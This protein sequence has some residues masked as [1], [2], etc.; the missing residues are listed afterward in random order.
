[1]PLIGL[2]AV[3][4]LAY[5]RFSEEEATTD[6]STSGSS[7]SGSST[8]GSSTSGSS[9]SGS[10]SDSTNEDSDVNYVDEWID[11]PIYNSNSDFKRFMNGEVDELHNPFSLH[12]LMGWYSWIN[13]SKVELKDS[14]GNTTSGGIDLQIAQGYKVKLKI[15]TNNRNYFKNGVYV[16][17]D[18]GRSSAKNYVKNDLNGTAGDELIEVWFYPN[19]RL[20]VDIDGEHSG[21]Y[22]FGMKMKGGTEWIRS[23]GGTVDDEVFVQM[24]DIKIRN[25]NYDPDK[26]ATE[27]NAPLGGFKALGGLFK[28]IRGA[29]I[30]KVIGFGRATT[31]AV[32]ASRVAGAI[33]EG[34]TA[35][36]VI[37]K[38]ANANKISR[39]EGVSEVREGGKVIK[40]KSGY[41]AVD[42]AGNV[43]AD[44]RTLLRLEN[45]D[46]V[47]KIVRSSSSVG[48]GANT[49]TDS[50]NLFNRIFTGRN[51]LS[52]TLVLVGGS[53]A[54]G[55]YRI[56]GEILPEGVGDT[57]KN[58]T[59]P[60]P[61]QCEG[62]EDYETCLAECN[63][64]KQ[65]TQAKIGLVVV[66]TILGLGLILKRPS[67]SKGAEGYYVLRT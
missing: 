57:L 54:I 30:W 60:C 34:T 2:L 55:A 19:D 59:T 13:D 23:K 64:A 65:E 56:F 47:V 51:V 10:T 46:D 45:T 62:S 6:S 22:T 44:G 17:G 26:F 27:F 38:G 4:G 24:T 39:I 5:Y 53:V 33:P 3:G 63:E 7:T 25:P 18:T 50:A 20:E 58:L 49:A 21:A 12:K 66:A 8:S 35:V 42:G 1:M 9:T 14:D 52:G 37:S 40:L 11:P 67:E 41:K 36:G 32:G 48:G 31:G 16:N 43:I 29:K 28:A 61:D 15:T